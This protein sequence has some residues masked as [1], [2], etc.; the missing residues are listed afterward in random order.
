MSL[1]PLIPVTQRSRICRTCFLR[2]RNHFKIRVPGSQ[3]GQ[4]LAALTGCPESHC[5][6]S[7]SE[8]PLQEADKS[9]G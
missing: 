4:E 6:Q 3:T 2:L 5:R 7:G 9:Y 1:I 8:R